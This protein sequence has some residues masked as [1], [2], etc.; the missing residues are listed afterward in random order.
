[1]KQTS[2]GQYRQDYNLGMPV[3][4]N[5]FSYKIAFFSL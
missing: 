2:E 3:N 4:K 5:K 1:V